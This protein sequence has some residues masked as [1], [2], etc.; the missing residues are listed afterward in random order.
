MA[1]PILQTERIVIA[2]TAT[3]LVALLTAGPVTAPLR[4]VQGTDTGCIAGAWPA[5][6]AV[7]TADGRPVYVEAPY[8]VRFAGG[9]ALFGTPTFVWR[10]PTVFADSG[11]SRPAIHREP[12]AFVGVI[13]DAG[14]TARVVGRPRGTTPLVSPRPVRVRDDSLDVFWGASAGLG[15]DRSLALRELWHARYTVHGWGPPRRVLSLAR[16]EWNNSYPDLRTASGLVQLVVPAERASGTGTESGLLVLTGRGDDW[17]R[18][19]IAAPG[20]F[21]RNS[22]GS[23]PDRRGRSVVAFLGVDAGR[24]PAERSSSVLVA[25]SEDSGETWTRPRAIASYGAAAANALQLVRERGGALRLVWH[26]DSASPGARRVVESATSH[27]GGHSWTFGAPLSVAA[28]IGALAAARVGLRT[29]F[30]TRTLDAGALL[31]ALVPD[32]GLVPFR[33]LPFAPSPSIPRT[34]ALGADSLL[35]VFSV[36]RRHSYP[37]FPNLP[38]PALLTATFV[39]RCG[40]GS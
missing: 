24:G 37:P 17:R 40:P 20:G 34:V 13:V 2:N 9:L 32:D 18:R 29:V 36:L 3:L 31:F 10:S 23:L 5:P 15:R 6:H 38:V 16:I 7:A 14:G 1:L 19:W 26:V 27:D 22:V 35:L 11:Q 8:P 30:I 25:T 33:P 21:P 4:A 39:A 28:P 12:D